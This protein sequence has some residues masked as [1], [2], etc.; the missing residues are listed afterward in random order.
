MMPK[1]Y[2]KLY[3]IAL[4]TSLLLAQPSFA[5]L[6]KFATEA[7]YPPFV[8]T[9]NQGEIHGFDIEIAQTLCRRLNLE[10]TF[11]NQPWDSLIP[12]LQFGKFD[13]LIGAISITPERQEKVAFTI[14]YYKNSADFVIPAKQSSLQIKPGTIIGVQAGTT[15]ADYLTATYGNTIKINRYASAEQAFLDLIA[16]RL[17]TVFGDQPVVSHWVKTGGQQQFKLA[18]TPVQNP[19]YLGQGFGIAL[20]KDEQELVKKFNEELVKLQNDGTYQQIYQRY[21]D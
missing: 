12:S 11:S 7:T 17:D 16:T 19:Q 14:P 8:Y 4:L 1:L 2:Y 20:R 10:C 6:V 13:A 21:L 18:N 5:Q 3:K 15:L 9:N